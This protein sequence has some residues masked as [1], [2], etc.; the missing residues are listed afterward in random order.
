MASAT[1]GPSIA[2]AL[3]RERWTPKLVA[4]PARP[5]LSEISASRGATRSPFA[6]RSTATIAAINGQEPPA[7]SSPILHNA[8]V[9]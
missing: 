9:P 5:L 8:D 7:P 6:A 1:S 2:P 4:S 3:S